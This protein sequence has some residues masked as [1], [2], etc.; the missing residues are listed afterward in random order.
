MCSQ[1][2]A[3]PLRGSD[4]PVEAAREGRP[5]I[6][7]INYNNSRQQHPVALGGLA[8]VLVPVKMR[9][10]MD[11]ARLVHVKMRV[12]KVRALQ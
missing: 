10:G 5:E 4:G 7:E 8:S 12:Q 1:P 2:L 3:C 6:S 9:M 11:F